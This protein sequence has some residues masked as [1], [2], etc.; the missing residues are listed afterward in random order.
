MTTDLEALRAL[1]EV[2]TVRNEARSLP[3]W[4]AM[5]REALSLFRGGVS[6]AITIANADVPKDAPMAPAAAMATASFVYCGRMDHALEWAAKNADA[7]LAEITALRAWK[8]EALAVE[9]TWDE[10]AVAKALNMPLGTNVRAAILPGITALR[11]AAE[12]AR[13]ALASI[14]RN[15]PNQD[16][17]HANFRVRTLVVASAAHASLTAALGEKP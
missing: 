4:I 10:Q 13:E 6:E 14:E 12:K 16:V 9:A 5:A 1:E 8:A 7:L 17:S 3:E 2:A 11:S 15:Y